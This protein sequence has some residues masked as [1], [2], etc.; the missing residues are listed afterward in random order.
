MVTKARPRLLPFAQV[1]CIGA[2]VLLFAI[3]SP[4]I[5]QSTEP[6]AE[7]RVTCV[8]CHPTEAQQ[9]AESAHATA[10]FH[11][12]GCHGGSFEYHL[13]PAN[14]G[15]LRESAGRIAQGGPP[16]EQF[17]HSTGFRGKPSRLDTPEWCGTC[18]SDVAQMNPYGL[19]TDQ[20]SQYRLSGH[21]QALYGKNDDRAAVCTDC[22]GV[23]RILKPKE[24]AST[25]HPGNIPATC[26]RC[27]ADAEHM[28]DSGLSTRIPQ[29]YRDSVH[30]IGLIEGGDTGMP[31]CATC[32]GSH[33]AVPPGFRDVGHVCG[34][35]HQQE[36]RFFLEGTHGRFEGF[37]R[38]VVCHTRSV[39]LRDHMIRRVAAKP[40]AIE[41]AFAAV[42]A[43][44]P[45]GDIDDP[46]FQEAYASRRQPAVEHFGAFCQRCHSTERQVGHRMFF[47]GVDQRAVDTGD[48]IYALIRQAE[49]RYGSA[50][51]RVNRMQH[52]VLLL[53]EEAMMLEELR[54]KTVGLAPLQHT[55]SLVRIEEEAAAQAAM[56]RE[57]HQSL[58]R[59]LR[60]LRWRYWALIPMWGFVAVFGAALWIKYKQLK[61]A[62]V[63]PWHPVGLP[64]ASADGGQR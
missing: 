7:T 29:E 5:A 37:P 50:A 25:V 9:F 8:D 47:G 39:D 2:V 41:K 62:L 34:R 22:H 45:A 43:T 60:G 55:L 64:P 21:G 54:T 44:M 61:A 1:P 52:G 56:T 35:C 53:K 46:A 27:H 63:M 20:W 6:A 28:K 26:G 13:A 18:H 49:L 10:G 24:P 33:S 19:P 38:C 3:G 30:G 23:H 32:H 57:I 12:Q 17:D 36:E 51:H 42:A 15:R 11:C 58:D 31:T 40:E 48:R 16:A 4:G 59:K 14:L